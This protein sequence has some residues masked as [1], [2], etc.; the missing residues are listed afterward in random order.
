MEIV[1]YARKGTLFMILWIVVSFQRALAQNDKVNDWENPEV[2]HRNREPARCSWYPFPDVET[3]LRGDPMQSPFV[4]SLNGTWKFRWVRKPAERPKDF[5]KDDYDVSAWDD[6][7]VPANWEL[8][9]Y[10]TPIY[11]DME[12]PFPSDP[13]R[14]PHDWNPVGSYKRT[15]TIP[16]KWKGRQVFLYFGGVK[17]AFYVW[18]NGR[19]I[20]YSQGSKTPAEFNITEYLREGDNTLSLEVYRWSDGAYLEDQDYWKISGIER[21]V[22]LLSTPN[23]YV[24]DFFVR[25]GLDED[26][27]NGLLYLDVD[28]KNALTQKAGKHTVEVRL[29]EEERM[30]PAVL[31]MTRDVILGPSD[32]IH[33][34][35]ESTVPHPKKWSAETPNLYSLVISL[36]DSAGNKLEALSCGIGFRTVE[37][38]DRQLLVNGVPVTIRGVDRHEHDPITGRVIT[39]ELMIKDIRLMKRFNINAVRTSHYP[40]RP[41]WYDLCDRYGLY[42]VDEANIEAHGSDPYN[43]EKTLADKPQ[44]RE[45]FMDRTVRMVERDKNHPSVIVWS[46]S[47]ETGYGQNFRDTYQWIKQRDPTRPVQSEDATRLGGLTDI[48]CPMYNTIDQIVAFAQSDDPRPLILCEYAHAMGNSVGNL[49]DYWDAIQAYPSLQGGFIWDWV[50][51]TFLKENEEGVAFWAYGGD[52]G[53]TGVPNDSNFCV[54]GLVHA[55]RTP[56]PHIWEVKKVYQPVQIRPVDMKAGFVKIINTYDFVNLNTLRFIWEIEGDGRRITGGELSKLD[57]APGDSII[58]DLELPEIEPEPGVEYY[59][60]VGALT[61]NRTELVPMGHTVA[62]EQIKLPVYKQARRIDTTKLPEIALSE[63][64]DE[65]ALSGREFSLRFSEELGTLCS[66]KFR[67]TELVRSGLIP[68]FW[69]PV[70]DNDLGG[71][72]ARIC[73]VWQHAEMN[74]KVEEVSAQRIDDRT[75]RVDIRL[76]LPDVGSV[77]RTTYTVYGSGDVI[78][79]N[80]FTP[81]REGLP[82]L[83]R[84]GMMMI[85]PGA[86]SNVSWYGRGPHESYWDRKTGAAV[87]VYSG[88]VWEQFHAYARPQETGNKTDV[89]WIALTNG[90]GIGLLAV[91]MPLL[92]TSALPVL[93]EDLDWR[94]DRPQQHGGEIYP[95]DLVTLKLDYGQM[96]VGGDTSWGSRAW[97]HPEYRLP[98]KE[99]RYRFRLRPFSSGSWLRRMLETPHTVP[100]KLSR[101]KWNFE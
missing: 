64:D 10:G 60:M 55:D 32:D 15:F 27:K 94:K 35:F 59:L 6:I 80:G 78:V 18:V 72:L 31:E 57:V 53:F 17:S 62:W 9:G 71:G 63:N 20:G 16:K 77:Y 52:M 73:R 87:D 39:K 101:Q 69:R 96:G 7:R 91:G 74:R 48:Y 93:P 5:Y 66:F 81:G 86:F 33:I 47:N 67:G 75:V 100:K 37:I 42:L 25:A 92:S 84:F 43:P 34:S 46:L 79:E 4:T 13:P 88:T 70:T 8:E 44:W 99:Y 50:D 68:D 85:L 23:V 82:D 28:L 30:S 14:I 21:D 76:G 11:T 51:Q 40:N 3:A 24:R 45:A 65:I 98:P 1:R 26:Y 95:K 54:N 36:L 41:E 83:P 56:H 89:R 22:L 49:Q 2:V 61:R 19:N 29:V 12:Y 38:K 58:V 90:R 97:P